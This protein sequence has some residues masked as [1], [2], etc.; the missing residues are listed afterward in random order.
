MKV[1][2]VSQRIEVH[3]A[4]AFNISADAMAT[5]TVSNYSGAVSS[6]DVPLLSQARMIFYMVAPSEVVRPTLEETPNFMMQ[7]SARIC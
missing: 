7:V 3:W 4:M 2:S 5:R 6:K 1:G